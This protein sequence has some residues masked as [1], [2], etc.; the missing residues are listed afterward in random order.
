[1]E[2]VFHLPGYETFAGWSQVNSGNLNK[3]IINRSRLLSG[4]YIS[5]IFLSRNEPKV[6]STKPTPPVI[7]NKTLKINL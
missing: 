3:F 5:S 7:L 6:I 1:M 2:M 4:H